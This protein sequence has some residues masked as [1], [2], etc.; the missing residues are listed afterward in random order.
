MYD[1]IRELNFIRGDYQ[2]LPAHLNVEEGTP[3]NFKD[4]N[5]GKL[6]LSSISPTSVILTQH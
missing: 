5:K 2:W 1:S 3:W 6:F 4:G